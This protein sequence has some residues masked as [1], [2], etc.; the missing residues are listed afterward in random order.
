MNVLSDRVALDEIA[1]LLGLWNT[2][3]A[4]NPAGEVLTS[5]SAYVAQ[6][7][8]SVDTPEGA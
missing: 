6:T 2:D 4:N 5:V 3:P 8:R 7:G 1:A